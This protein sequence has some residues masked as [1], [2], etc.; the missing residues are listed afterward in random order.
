MKPEAQRPLRWVCRQARTGLG[1]IVLLAAVS[2][3]MS[4]SLVLLALAS[5]AI[6]DIATGHRQ[7]SMG[8]YIGYTAGLIV[9]QALLLGAGSLLRTRASGRLEIRMRQ[10]LFAALMRKDYARLSELHSGVLVH[11]SASD[12]R[13]VADGLVSIVTQIATVGTR[14]TAGFALLLHLSPT[15]AWVLAGALLLLFAAGRL[16]GRRSIRRHKHVQAAESDVHAFFQECA[17]NMV[18]IRAFSKEGGVGN[19]L[20]ELQQAAYRAKVKRNRAGGLASMAMTAA[21]AASY[22]GTLA[23]G[24]LQIAKGSMTFG[25]LAACLQIMEQIR[26]PIRSMSGLTSQYHAMLASAERLH[27]LELLP[28]ERALGIGASQAGGD[29]AFERIGL[30]RVSYG[31]GA[32]AVLTNINLTIQRG[33]FIGIAGASGAGKSTLLKLLLGLLRP[34]EGSIYLEAGGRRSRSGPELRRLCAYVPQSAM[35]LSGTI[36]DNMTLYAEDAAD[37]EIEQALTTACLWNEV[38]ELPE[39]L[40][41]RLGERGAGLSEGQ[42]QRLAIARALLSGAPILLLDECTSALDERTEL[43]VLRRLRSLPDRTVICTSHS[44]AL[45]DICD[46]IV[47]ISRFKHGKE[48]GYGA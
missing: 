32:A 46:R 4:L 48:S 5:G 23:W 7:G 30:E 8:L 3:G 40:A 14:M 1:W 29:S 9:L 6:L 2:G 38:S 25:A 28:E 43:A 42:V 41:T 20:N 19:R 26:G 16:Y 10:S 15:L 37:A 39:G 18:V 36:R 13:A 17:E 21:V 12:V 22:F 33:E 31:Y 34:D 35:M 47:D 27:E 24:A 11:R 45:L 44:G